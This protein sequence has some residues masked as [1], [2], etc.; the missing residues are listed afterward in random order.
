MLRRD[1]AAVFKAARAVVAKTLSL[2]DDLAL[3]LVK[4]AAIEVLDHLETLSI[5]AEGQAVDWDET[6]LG[7][8]YGITRRT[9]ELL[10]MR[11]PT[12]GREWSGSDLPECRAIPTTEKARQRFQVKPPRP[13]HCHATVLKTGRSVDPLDQ[14]GARCVRRPQRRRTTISLVYKKTGDLCVC[15]LLFGPQVGAHRPLPRHRSW[16][17][18]SALRAD[19]SLTQRQGS[20]SGADIRPQRVESRTSSPNFG[21]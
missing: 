13:S 20:L 3:A 15:Q 7:M 5:E 1:L 17:R 6:E 8:L 19:R 14:V 2:S 21:I 16:R 18:L 9:R 4:C 11:V 12:P 10:A